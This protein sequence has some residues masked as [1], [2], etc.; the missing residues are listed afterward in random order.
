M[1]YSSMLPNFILDSPYI[2]V[3]GCCVVRRLLKKID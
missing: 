3:P 2:R 1:L